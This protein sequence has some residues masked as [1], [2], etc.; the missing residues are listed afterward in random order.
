MLLETTQA[1]AVSP[2]CETSPVRGL[3]AVAGTLLLVAPRV[4]CGTTEV[5]LA[6]PLCPVAMAGICCG[7]TPGM[8]APVGGTAS[9]AL[10]A[11][12]P[13]LSWTLVG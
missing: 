10:D 8:A 13:P 9:V 4:V 1:I 2:A 12:E 5:L 7:Y 6:A 11:Y 3:D